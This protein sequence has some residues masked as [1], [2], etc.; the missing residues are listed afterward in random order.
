M[1]KDKS[2]EVKSTESSSNKV[3]GAPSIPSEIAV[4][5]NTLDTVQWKHIEVCVEKAGRLHKEIEVE[6]AK[7]GVKIVWQGCL[8]FIAAEALS[9]IKDKKVRDAEFNKLLEKHGIALATANQ[10]ILLVKR[11]REQQAISRKL[12]VHA[13]EDDKLTPD[14]LTLL[15]K[16]CGSSMA[17]DLQRQYGIRQPLKSPPRKVNVPKTTKDRLTDKTA[18]IDKL[19]TE[20]QKF[21]ENPKNNKDLKE[22][23]VGM[24]IKLSET[25]SKFLTFLE[26]NVPQP[27]LPSVPASALLE[28]AQ[29]A[30]DALMSLT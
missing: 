27:E 14:A 20:L 11:M 6:Q 8:L 15:D 26:Q 17:V 22:N 3:I 1:A 21:I 29:T 28:P 2:T 4:P 10:R 16:A 19:L 18:H 24:S 7:T 25:F 12:L 23:L 5:S 13:E 30:E 9:A